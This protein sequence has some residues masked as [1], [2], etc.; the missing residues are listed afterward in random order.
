MNLAYF[1]NSKSNLSKTI[2][3]AQRE[4][5]SAK[6]EMLGTTELP[7]NT[8]EVIHFTNDSWTSN[9]IAIDHNLIA[10]LPTDLVILKKDGKVMVGCGSTDVL[11]GVTNHPAVSRI[12]GEIG[13]TLKDI[14]NKSAG[15]G[16]LKPKNIKL[17]STMSCPY[18][19]MEKSWL[20]S[21]K[22]E[23]E[24]VYVDLNPKEAQNLVNK[25]GQMG[26]PVTEVLYDDAD[27]EFIVGF[28]KPKLSSTL[29]VQE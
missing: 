11:G 21:K 13:K 3:N 23:H 18:C 24:V 20:E 16:E 5:K 22:I 19:K 28:D 27:S 12:A 17:Y 10:L 8:G 14:V 29:G 1:R 4:L 25:T 9:L 15:V 6:L 26:V 2:K 7:N